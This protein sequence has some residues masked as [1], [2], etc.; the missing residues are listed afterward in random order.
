MKADYDI[1]I[2]GGGL[3]GATLAL[4]LIRA[5]FRVALVETGRLINYKGNNE[6]YGSRVSA[7]SP[8]SKKMFQHLDL[9]GVIGSRAFPYTEMHVWDSGGSGEIHF[10]AAELGQPCLGYIIENEWMLA[11][12]HRRLDQEKNISLFWETS[13]ESMQVGISGRTI[14]K[15][16]NGRSLATDLLIGA[17]GAN[18]KVRSLANINIYK[19]DYRQQG[20]VAVVEVS[21]AHKQIAWQR[22]LPDGP[23]AFL[24]LSEHKYSI[25]WSTAP[26]HASWL[27]TLPNLVFCQELTTASMSCLGKV[28]NVSPRVSFPLSYMQAESYIAPG[29][30]L[31]GDAAHVVHPLAGQGVN[32]GLQDVAWLLDCISDVRHCNQP[33]N[34]DATLRRYACRRRI[35]N[36]WMLV[37]LDGLKAFFASQNPAVSALRSIGLNIVDRFHPVKHRLMWQ[38]MDGGLSVPGWMM[39]G[40]DRAEI[41]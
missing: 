36:Q 11:A 35:E 18:S 14:V 27:K 39:Q 31:V 5:E 30:V 6:E 20:L 10:N 2:V 21:K 9:W 16:S 41:D 26:D 1:I 25:V 38:A 12:M 22:F 3:V 33:I 7:V 34:S 29:L 32:L 37:G 15:C 23:L 17:D 4:A 8:F 28:V 24:P 19:K 13:L 40:M